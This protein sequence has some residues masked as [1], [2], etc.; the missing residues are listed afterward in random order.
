MKRTKVVIVD[1]E[2][3]L[4]KSLRNVLS[5]FDEI[6][7]LYTC[8]HGKELL[9]K[10]ASDETL[11]DVI[12]MDINMPIING[13]K[14]TALVKENYNAIKIVML[15]VFDEDDN[16]FLSIQAG[17]SGYL[18][19]DEPAEKIISAINEVMQGGAPM[20]PII[21]HKTLQLLRNR[22]VDD[23]NNIESS[24]VIANQYL[25]TKREIEVLDYLVKGIPYKNIADTMCISEHTVKTHVKNIYQK[26]EINNK[27]D[28]IK[29]IKEAK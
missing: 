1:D 29:I 7:L 11:P 21:A 18:M 17:A 12:L 19:K 20:S 27:F 15:T 24:A 13:I 23:F 22:N 10:L 25:L 4:Q 6:E 26:L 16:I 28:A 2:L 14:A 9:E 8:S 3:M 5:L